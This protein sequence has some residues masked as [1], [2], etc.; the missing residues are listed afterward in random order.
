M[1][2]KDQQLVELKKNEER[3]KSVLDKG[4]FPTAVVDEN[5]QKI[6]FW[7]KSAIQLF[8]YNPKTSEEWY[9]LAY[10]D[11]E[12]RQD[13]IERW[14]PFLERAQKSSYAVNTGEYEIHCKNGTV[15]I[16]EIYAQ[17]IPGSLIVTLSDITEGKKA[18]E[19]L[20][21]LNQQ[22][23][24]NEQQLRAAN[25]QL[26]ASEQQLLA[27]NQQL[28][29]N[30][31]ELI[32]A[33]E[34]AERYLDMAGS[35]FVSLDRN[36]DILFVNQKGLGVLE[37]DKS[38]E[39]KGKNWFDTCIPSEISEQVKQVFNKVIKGSLD[40]VEYFENEVVSK[41]GKRRLIYWYNSFIRNEKGQ[42]QE[43][44]CSGIDITERKHTENELIKAKEKAEESD[45]LK[46]AFLANMS[47]EIRT[48]MNGILG[49]TNLLKKV[50]LAGKQRNKYINVIEKSGDRMLS[51]INDIIDI[52]RIESG[53]VKTTI[54]ATN[55]NSQLN[56]LYE[57]FKPEADK[58]NIEFIFKPGL[59]NT[60]ENIHTDPDKVEAIITNLIKNAIKFTNEGSIEFGY[61]LADTEL[62]FYVKDT[63]EGIKPDHLERIFD[64]FIQEDESHTSAQQGSGL[65]LSIVKAYV[66]LLEGKIWVESN[67][68]EGSTFHITIPYNTVEEE[69][70]DREKNVKEIKDKTSKFTNKTIL[71]VEDDDVSYE[72]L[73]IVLK[74]IG[75]SNTT[76]ANNGQ[77]AIKQCKEN[78]AI[79]LVLMDIDLP[80]MNGYEATKAIKAIKPNLPIIAQTAYALSGDREKSL[81]AGSD[82]FITKPIKIEE[83]LEKVE[84]FL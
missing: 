53:E 81:Q 84:K 50:D 49:F 43:L 30:E 41:S 7:S 82:D 27:A 46:S 12:Y 70:T 17:S 10:P 47:H 52:S 66:E 29:A 20:K 65:G 39:L 22:L 33:K 32:G 61:T 71:L 4:P 45:R 1:N 72:Y 9:E 44:L 69:T 37:Y 14:K 74:N 79:D 31:Q 58:K 76:W 40:G 80:G 11:A 54:Q 16:C 62:H 36:G 38:E 57:F 15:K 18:E 73:D 75:I 13:V 35:A 3:I 2:E 23:Q 5:D 34:K 19:Q 67:K 8:G 48:P 25:Q 21:T 64:R 60:S 26:K 28:Q 68:S 55:I 51:T 78:P 77:E 56:A 42:I 6:M 63:G 59:D 83:L 24:A